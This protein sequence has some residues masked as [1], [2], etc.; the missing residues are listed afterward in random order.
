MVSARPRHC[1]S[2][3]PARQSPSLLR[4][5]KL[6]LRLGGDERLPDPAQMLVTEVEGGMRLAWPRCQFLDHRG[7]REGEPQRDAPGQVRIAGGYEIAPVGLHLTS[8]LLLVGAQRRAEI[9]QELQLDRV[10][11]CAREAEHVV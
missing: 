9:E 11:R 5:G 10:L 3:L 6:S 8:K 7:G 4:R 2:A 1:G